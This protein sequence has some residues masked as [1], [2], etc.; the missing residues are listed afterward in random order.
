MEG[1]KIGVK[2]FLPQVPKL[3]EIK[4]VSDYLNSLVRQLSIWENFLSSHTHRGVLNDFKTIT[5]G[6]YTFNNTATGLTWTPG[7]ST[8]SLT[9]GY[10]IPTTAQATNWTTAYTQTHIHNQLAALETTGSPSF[11]TITATTSIKLLES[12]GATYYAILQAGDMAASKIFTLPIAYAGGNDYPLI[13]STAGVLSW[14]DQALKTTSNVKFENVT[15]DG[16]LYITDFTGF[17]GSIVFIGGAGEIISNSVITFNTSYGVVINESGS[18]VNDFRV[19]GDT[20]ENLIFTDAVTDRVGFGM[21][22]PTTKVDVNG[23]TTTIGLISADNI[24]LGGMTTPNKYIDIYVSSPASPAAVGGIRFGASPTYLSSIIQ[25]NGPT[26]ST[27][28]YLEI[29]A[30]KLKINSYSGIFK[31]TSG[32]VSVITPLAGTKVYYV[33]DSSGGTLNRKLTFTDGI[34]TAET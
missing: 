24:Y 3:K 15:V 11:V 10:V 25:Y 34:L 27:D 30:Y 13:G 20:D 7:T 8:L 19:E 32:V 2:I 18:N 26:Q 21:N 1:S 5:G 17:S 31:G 14:N 22:N 9:S 23:V 28:E 33:S 4:D 29:L 16:S 6:S 12:A